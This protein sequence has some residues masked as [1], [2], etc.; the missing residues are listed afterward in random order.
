MADDVLAV[1]RNETKA[2]G[3]MLSKR[4]DDLRFVRL[5]KG[6]RV[7]AANGRLIAR[8]LFSNLDHAVV[9]YRDI[10]SFLGI[11]VVCA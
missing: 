4:V 7:D 6:V 10:A 2:I 11:P 8:A 1:E 9:V 3:A 5:A